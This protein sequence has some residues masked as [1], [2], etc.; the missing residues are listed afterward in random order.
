MKDNDIIKLM[1][2][3]ISQMFKDYPIEW[4]E[5]AYKKAHE[6]YMKYGI[7]IEGDENETDT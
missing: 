1:Y 6:D 2:D 3:D 5:I 7:I 4:V